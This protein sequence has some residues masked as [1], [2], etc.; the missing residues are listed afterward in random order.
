MFNKIEAWLDKHFVADWRENWNTMSVKGAR[1]F[2]IVV[3]ALAAQPDLLLG[4]IN[5]LPADPI[6]RALM[7]VSVGLLAFSAPWFLRNWNEA[8]P[9][10]AAE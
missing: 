3:A 6:Q 10:D 9:D 7:A 1:L 2:G 4:I 5:L 8:K